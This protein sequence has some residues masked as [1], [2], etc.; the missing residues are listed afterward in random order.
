MGIK[1]GFAGYAQKA[2]QKKITLPTR[3]HGRK[4]VLVVDGGSAS[5]SLSVGM[6][7][8]L[9]AMD[10][11]LLFIKDGPVEAAVSKEAERRSRIGTRVY[12]T[13]DKFYH[14]DWSSQDEIQNYVNSTEIKSMA[15]TSRK[16]RGD[17]HFYRADGEADVEV[18]LLGGL[19]LLTWKKMEKHFPNW[20]NADTRA[21]EFGK[22]EGRYV[23]G[24]LGN[25]S[26]YVLT[27]NLTYLKLDSLESFPKNPRGR[28]EKDRHSNGNSELQWQF[29][30]GVYRSTTTAD[31][32]GIREDMLPDAACLLGTDTTRH[33]EELLKMLQVHLVALEHLVEHKEQPT[34]NVN[35]NSKTSRNSHNNHRTTVSNLQPETIQKAV[36]AFLQKRSHMSV[37]ELRKDLFETVSSVT[38]MGQQQQKQLQLCIDAAR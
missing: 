13:Y 33:V 17:V 1:S 19:G 36:F 18:V 11:S 28:K 8:Q 27:Q 15:M 6:A 16:G 4:I 12:E 37:Q 2:I 5:Y 3:V 9:L 20:S 7:K 34:H 21:R 24:V 29:Y 10:I 14:A 32:L 25:D 31:L 26:D 35:I 23:F 30:C 22:L 38:G